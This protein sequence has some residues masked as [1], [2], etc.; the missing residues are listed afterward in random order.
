ME[1]NK[2]YL[3]A[4]TLWVEFHSV[5]D[6]PNRRE[7]VRINVTCY[8]CRG[9]GFPWYRAGNGNYS[10]HAIV[11]FSRQRLGLVAKLE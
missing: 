11:H 4:N 8:Y 2:P 7:N 10:R 6:L 1:F 3:C 5:S 9:A